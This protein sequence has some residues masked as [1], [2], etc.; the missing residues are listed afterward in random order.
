MLEAIK[1]ILFGKPATKSGSFLWNLRMV[2]PGANTNRQAAQ[3][4]RQIQKN[5][6][7]KG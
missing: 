3:S 5:N 4:I 6:C 7:V 1:D 2:D